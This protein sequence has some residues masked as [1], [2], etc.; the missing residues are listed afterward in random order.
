MAKKKLR[1]KYTSKGGLG[2]KLSK[3]GKVEV[4]A[5]DRALNKLRAWKKGKKVKVTVANPDPNNTKARF[6][7]VVKPQPPKNNLKKKEVGVKAPA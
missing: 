5:L 3:S 4:S 6:I 2:G 1:A 7:T